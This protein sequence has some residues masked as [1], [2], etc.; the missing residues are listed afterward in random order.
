MREQAVK[1]AVV[2]HLSDANYG[3]V[4]E[5]PVLG[6]IADIL[7]M[8]AT[9]DTVVAIECKERDWSHALVQARQYQAAVDYAFI[10]LPAARCTAAA[11]D[12]ARTLGI[13]VLAI[14][15]QG[16]VSELVSSHRSS[17]HYLG[18][19][20]HLTTR[21]AAWFSTGGCTGA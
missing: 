13:G 14:S 2:S 9:S 3:V 18:L 6:R 4:E 11:C 16:T 10:A 21:L 15:E 12:R 7:A 17:S 8:H 19:Q 20:S 5:F 1:D